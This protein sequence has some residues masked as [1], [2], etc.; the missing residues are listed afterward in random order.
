[1]PLKVRL[2]YISASDGL[3]MNKRHNNSIAYRERLS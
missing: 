1:M 3:R 2:H